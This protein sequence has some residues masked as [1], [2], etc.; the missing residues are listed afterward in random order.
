MTKSLA[1][2]APILTCLC[3]AWVA[4]ADTVFFPFDDPEELRNWESASG[5]LVDLRDSWRIEDGVLK[6]S[7]GSANAVGRVK[8]LEFHHGVIEYRMRWVGPTPVLAESG[9]V[10]RMRRPPRDPNFLDEN[11]LEKSPGYYLY[12]LTPWIGAP[13]GGI[14]WN[15]LNGSPP[16]GLSF[17]RPLPFW[18]GAAFDGWHAV[19]VEVAGNDH[20]ISIAVEGDPQPFLRISG[21]R[22]AVYYDDSAEPHFSWAGLDGY[23]DSPLLPEP[24]DVGILYFMQDEAR[25][26]EIHFDDFRVTT[27]LPVEEAGATATTWSAVKQ[28]AGV[29]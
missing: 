25:D 23:D 11:P 21:R 9:V 26:F 8:N 2:W 6:I 4:R 17:V 15:H 3:V 12:H 14:H 18:D 22:Q 24:G 13:D 7:D 29:R 19:R 1:V 10:Y 16:Q 27:T 20:S 28:S 5:E